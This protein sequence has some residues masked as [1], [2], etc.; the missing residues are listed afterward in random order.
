MRKRELERN[1]KKIIKKHYKEQLGMYRDD[2][3][4]HEA[5]APFVAALA[6]VLKDPNIKSGRKRK[7]PYPPKVDRSYITASP[8]DVRICRGLKKLRISKGL[9]KAELARR[10]KY[11]ENFLDKLEESNF[12]LP[13]TTPMAIVKGMQLSKQEKRDFFDTVL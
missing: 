6:D 2:I 11:N 10:L 8:V 3:V 12:V 4:D 5:I 13:I 9:S 7:N 1:I